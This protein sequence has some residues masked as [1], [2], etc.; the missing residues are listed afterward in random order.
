MSMI[1]P[2]EAEE[3][4]H[5]EGLEAWHQWVT[6]DAYQREEEE[7]QDI[8][9]KMNEQEEYEAMAKDQ[10][11]PSYGQTIPS[12]DQWRAERPAGPSMY[13]PEWDTVNTCEQCGR[14]TYYGTSECYPQLVGL[15]CT[16]RS[17][18]QQQI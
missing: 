12:Y 10:K 7:R 2:T 18:H 4:Q 17:N 8:I 3:R 14:P 1:N 5:R 16:P 13:R 11:I 6:S 9:R 15:E